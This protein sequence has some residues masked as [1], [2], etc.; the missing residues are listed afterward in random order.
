MT[1]ARFLKKSRVRSKPKKSKRPVVVGYYERRRRLRSTR[2]TCIDLFAGAGGLAE[3][4]LRAGFEIVSGV[5]SDADS[6]STFMANFAQASFFE[7]DIQHIE[8]KHLL[9]DAGLER[10]ELAC[11]IGGPPCQ[12]FSYNNHE[13]SA[14]HV[15]SRLFRHYLRLVDALRPKTIVMENVPG[16]L[17]IGDGKVL[18]A[19]TNELTKLGYECEARVLFAEDF[20]VPQERRRV[21]F[22]GTRT[23]WDAKLFPHGTHG[24]APKPSEEA[25]P[26]VHRWQPRG[27]VWARDFVTVWD[28]I[29]DLPLLRNGAGKTRYSKAAR[30][31]V[32]KRARALASDQLNNHTTRTLTKGMLRRIATV[33]AGGN[34]RDIPRR[35]LPK[36]MRRA[37]KSDH[38]KRYGRP[39]RQEL[40]C[41]ILTK[42]DPH[43]GAY[44]H[45]TQ[46]RVISV[47]EAAR[48]QS[49]GDH[50]EF[51]GLISSQYAQVGN[52]VPPALAKAIAGAVKR[53]LRRTEK[54]NRQRKVKLVAPARQPSQMRRAR[55]ER[56]PLRRAA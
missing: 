3:G 11:L 36:G 17:T 37:H 5:D 20:G 18:T 21:F 42:C 32:Q 23:D 31:G 50:F 45:P 19:I 35:L 43:W 54:K 2:P 34:W 33:P 6:R 16:I 9:H 46:N 41:T 52:A 53:H 8:G 48:L 26:W 40:S 47:R 22:V 30:T 49:F 24:P 28:A 51:R 29:S 13:R 4:F 14:T 27:G 38:T 7:G 56:R 44:I 25:N 15:R 10:G 12:S 55:V 39:R 1:G